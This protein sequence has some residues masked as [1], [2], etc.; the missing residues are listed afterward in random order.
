MGST[1][2]TSTSVPASGRFFS[3]DGFPQAKTHASNSKIYADF[4]ISL[5]TFPQ[6]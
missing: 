2:E 5:K 1:S 6:N 4:F 3:S